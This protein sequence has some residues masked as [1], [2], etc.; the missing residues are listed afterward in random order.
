MPRNAQEFIS[1]VANHFRPLEAMCRQ[2]RRFSTDDEVVAFL[3]PF[4][5]DDKNLTRFIN[6]MREV[7]VLV[8]LAGDWAPPPFLVEFIEKLSERHALASPKVIQGW[9]DTLR[10]HVTA[11]LSEIDSAQFDFGAFDVDAGRFLLHEIADVFQTIVRTVQDNCERIA[12]EVADY[13]VLE[14]G[15]QLRSR[16]NRLIYLHGE[17]LEPV[18][19]IVD[20]SGDFH[21]ATEQV[22]TCCAR[23]AV[24]GERDAFPLA[25]EA[26]FIRREVVW[27]RRV[28]VRRAE[29]ARRELAPLCEAAVRESRIA[30]GVNRALEAVRVR[31]WDLLSLEHNLDIV[32]EKD[33]TLCSDLALERYLRQV[34]EAKSRTPPRVPM[35]TPESLQIPIT[36]DDILERLAEIES[37]DDL[38]DWVLD[39]CEEIDFDSAVRLFHAIIERRPDHAHPTQ[40]RL[41]YEH[42]NFFVNAARWTWKGQTDAD[43]TTPPIDGQPARKARRGFPV[44][45]KR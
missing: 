12:A 45:Q 3:R 41:D 17:Y 7:G 29:E 11:L 10:S 22:S 40:E 33:G 36:P 44:T 1:F 42:Q 34:L 15:K 24:F 23:L 19:R 31:Q 43:G 8:E 27:L 18:I 4:A 21:A 35:T 25:D 38:L 9:I 26:R 14:D 16:L 2:H 39:S 37:I 28:V 20:V 13:R 32:E 6:R 30:K 5:D